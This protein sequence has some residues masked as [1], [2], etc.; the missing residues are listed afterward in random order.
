MS[1]LR[2]QLTDLLKQRI[3]VFDGAMGTM[4]QR[5][6]LEERDYRGDRFQDHGCDLKGNHDLLVLTRPDV[7]RDVHG[8]YLEAGADFIETNTFSSTVISQADYDLQ[9]LAYELN[10]AAAQLAK[11]VAAEW[12]KKTPEKP[13]FVAGAMGPTNRTLSISP[14]VNDP[15]YRAVTFEEVVAAYREQARGLMEGGVDALLIETIF[16]TLNAKASIFAVQETFEEL[17][18]EIPLL[19]SVTITDKSGRTLSGQTVEAFWLSVEHARPLTV[20][21]NCALGAKDMRPYLEDLSSIA[22]TYVS[23]YPNAGLPNAFGEYD[24]TPAQT[25]ELLKDF[26]VSGLVNVVGGC[27]GTTPDHIRAIADA[28]ADCTPRA[29]VEQST[30]SRFSGLEPLVLGP[31]AGFQM[32]GERTNVTGSKRFARLIKEGDYAQALEVALD[33]VRGGANIIDVNMDEGMLDSEQAM[34]TMLNLI[35]SE[36]EICRVP[37]MVDSS[38]WSVIEA[39]LRCVQGKAIVNSIS[40]KEGEEEFFEKARLARRYGAAVVVMAFDEEGQA[41]TIERKVGICQRAY[42]LLVEQVGFDPSDIIF[43]PNIFAVAT[44]IEE[45]NRYAINFIEA[46]RQIKETCPHARVS[47]G[48]S[49][50]SFSFRGNNALREAMHSSFLYHAIRAGM[51]MGIVNAGQL[52]VYEEIPKELLEHVEDVLFDRRPDA[53]ER[54]VSLAEQVRGSGKKKQVDLSWREGTVEERIEHALVKGVADY[55]EEDTE[56][57]RQKYGRPLKVIEGPLMSGMGVVGDLFGD[58]K[59]FLPQV[60]KSARV[61]KKAVAYLQPFMEDESEGGSSQGR[62]LMATVKGDVHDIG[63]NIVAVVLRCNNYEVVDLGVMVPSEK[64]LQTA[65]EEKCD[66]IG[67]SGLITPSLDEMVHVARELERQEFHLPLMIGGATTSRQ[68]TAV[69]IAPKYGQSTVHVIDASRV[70]NVV[71]NLIDPELRSAFEAKNRQEQEKTRRLFESKQSRPVLPLDTAR[72]NGLEAPWTPE[73]IAKPKFLGREVLED[74]PLGEIAPYIDW[75]FFFS[76]WDLKGKYPQVLQHPK[77]GEAAR[78]L[79]ESGSSML[80]RIIEEQLIEARGVYGFW[81]ANRVGDDIVLWTDETRG[82]EWKRLHM[83]RQQAV[84]VDDQPYYCL[85]DFVAPESSGLTD[86]VGAFAVTA[87]IRADEIAAEFEQEGDD[88]Q[89]IM[90]KVLAD[91]LAEA[92]AEWLHARARRDFGYGAQEQLTNEDLIKERYRGIRPAFG[93]PACPDHTEKATLWDM[94]QA[95]DVGIHLTESFAMTP[96]A[97]VSGIYLPNEASRYFSVGRIDKDQVEDYAQRKGISVHEVEKWLLSNLAYDPEAK[98]SA[99]P[100]RSSG[101]TASCSVAT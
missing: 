75:T 17:G 67:L 4:V 14:K 48:V 85:S 34:T 61:M 8:E 66:I 68:H 20:G 77:Y 86:Y 28:T 59:M 51:D 50:L 82:Q 22:S 92:F 7:I 79:F 96:G 91:R 2:E 62:V 24:E 94:L 72:E 29:P 52:E 88:Y 40:L 25:A 64:I 36:P 10:V 35:A 70:V 84:K 6:E 46:T 81:P 16:D 26:A 44:G 100:S 87:G 43:D 49:N 101:G 23:C 27:C 89:S 74:V 19:L 30:K 99:R 93:Y 12:T 56:E 65:R 97:S 47:G 42:R 3:L 37:I 73:R 38:K 78:E 55:V 98:T 69:K 13:R 1:N 95:D 15:G 80:E 57:A 32:I 31:D 83:L 33:Q 21:I 5:R 63:K 45:H 71:S 54:L 11:E 9:P 53:T 60:V 41:D 76:A 18:R 90:V 39:G 58:G